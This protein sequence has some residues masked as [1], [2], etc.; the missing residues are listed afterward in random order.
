MVYRNYNCLDHHD[1]KADVGDAMQDVL[2]CSLP[3]VKENYRP[4]LNLPCIYVSKMIERAVSD[5]LVAH[6]KKND[7][8]EPFQSAY[9]EG[10]S[11]ETA[12]L[13]VQ[14]DMLMAMNRR[15]Y[16]TN[17]KILTLAACKMQDSE[18]TDS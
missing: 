17:Y 6:M 8:F 11:T 12:L 18:Q 1:F 10:H 7:L 16:H 5:Q 14:N 9:H 3:L 4:I 15:P 13:V 2:K